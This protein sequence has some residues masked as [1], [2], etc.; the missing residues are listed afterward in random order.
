MLPIRSS[1]AIR[2]VRCDS[3]KATSRMCIHHDWI[4][5]KKVLFWLTSRPHCTLVIVNSCMYDSTQFVNCLS[6]TTK[7]RWKLERWRFSTTTFF[8]TVVSFL[9]QCVVF[10]VCINKPKIVKKANAYIWVVVKTRLF[11]KSGNVCVMR[12][13]LT[14]KLLNKITNALFY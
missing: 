9:L 12:L 13:W 11:Y 8:L 4:Y 3:I 1:C 7:L 10:A 6:A 14:I 2:K 5:N